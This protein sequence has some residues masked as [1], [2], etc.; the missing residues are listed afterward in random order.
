MNEALLRRLKRSAARR[1]EEGLGADRAWRLALARAARAGCG[2]ALEV[3]RQTQ[4]R[5]TLSEVMELAPDRAF[6]AVLEGPGEGM[7]LLVLSPEVLAA[8]IEMQTT[9]RLAA[10]TPAPRRPTRTDAAMAAG[11]VDAALAAFE[12]TM[13]GEEA[14]AWACGYRY[15]SFLDEVRP[16]GLLLEDVHYT[17]LRG[18]VEL[19]GGQRSGEV[20]LVLPAEARAAAPQA[21]AAPPPA[22]EGGGDFAEAL[23]EVVLDCPAGIDAVLARV[24]L[25]LRGVMGLQVGDVI[26][27]PVT[28]VDR[29]SVEAPDGRR[30]AT[31]KL[32]QNRGL[33]ALRLTALPEA[34]G[35]GAALTVLATGTG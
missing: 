15:A 29:V 35:T 9:G 33:R 23:A 4:A 18:R 7:G 1:G 2:L 10:G 19:A 8:V 14:G 13:A 34:R 20:V 24:T 32:G 11:L 16:L 27:L 6:L 25:P 22:P 28:G 21:A 3:T 17:V 26:P 5:Q 30:L 12:E 31:G